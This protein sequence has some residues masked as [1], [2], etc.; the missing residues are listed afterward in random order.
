MRLAVGVFFNVNPMFLGGE[1]TM[2]QASN[3]S[4]GSI[5]SQLRDSKMEDLVATV[6]AVADE[7]GF[8]EDE[9]IRLG[10]IITDAPIAAGLKRKLIKSMAPSAAVPVEMILHAICRFNPAPIAQTSPGGTC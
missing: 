9:L 8:D 6:V 1:K 2:S 7:K 5:P 3:I 4:S 10:K